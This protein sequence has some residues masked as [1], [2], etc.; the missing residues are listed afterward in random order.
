VIRRLIAAYPETDADLLVAGE[1][2]GEGQK[3]HNL[4]FAT[5]DLPAGVEYLAFVDSDA[6]LRR[7]WLRALLTRLDQ[8]GIGATTGY[9]WFVPS[10]PTLAN[11]LLYSMNSHIAILFGSRCPTIVWGGSWAIRRDRFEALGVRAAWAGTLSDDLVASRVLRRAGL[12]VLFEPACMVSSP[13]DVTPGGLF[14]FI[15][16]QYLMGRWYVPGGWAFAFAMTTFVNVSSLASVVVLL[17]ALAAGLVTPWLPAGLCAGLYAMSMFAGLLRQD[18]AL[19]YFP[20]LHTTLRKVRRF[21]VW[22]GPLVALVNWMGVLGSV[23]GRRIWWRGIGY[24]VTAGGMVTAIRRQGEAAW[25]APAQTEE[26]SVQGDVSEPAII[27]MPP[28]RARNKADSPPVS[29]RRCA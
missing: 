28:A 23:V 19:S 11:H 15:R 25:Q 14:N 6:R 8:P 4:R 27:P 16:R 21:E 29:R 3:V 5:R 2:Q 1:A 26:S 13:A 18:M 24:S 20:Y 22:S 17:G 10:R 9:R 7:Q 12:R